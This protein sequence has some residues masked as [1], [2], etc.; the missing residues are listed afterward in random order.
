MHFVYRYNKE[1]DLLEPSVTIFY[2]SDLNVIGMII[3]LYVC[4]KYSKL[5]NIV[6]LI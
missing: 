6:Y 1:T 5:F 2:K 3:Y 4:I